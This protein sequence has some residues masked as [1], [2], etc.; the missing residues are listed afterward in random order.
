M[1]AVLG[2]EKLV[3]LKTGTC[4]MGTWTGCKD[5][6]DGWDDE[7]LHFQKAMAS[8]S[9]YD[10]PSLQN[11][12]DTYF[13]LCMAIS[14]QSLLWL[15]VQIFCQALQVHDA[16]QKK[17]SNGMPPDHATI[18][19]KTAGQCSKINSERPVAGQFDQLLLTS[20]LIDRKREQLNQNCNTY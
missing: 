9:R 3:K 18:L 1:D 6:T 11:T 13:L 16:A 14:V 15:I 12:S 8:N 10:L 7:V 4:E 2:V 19:M 5:W 17:S 20:A